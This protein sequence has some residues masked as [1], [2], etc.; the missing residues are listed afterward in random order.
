MLITQIIN[1]YPAEYLK[2]LVRVFVM[3]RLDS[4]NNFIII[5]VTEEPYQKSLMS[6]NLCCTTYHEREIYCG[7]WLTKVLYLKILFFTY[8]ALDH[9]APLYI[10]DLQ[11]IYPR[12]SLNFFQAFFSQLHEL[13]I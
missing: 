11:T 4:C 2:T 9:L 12:T 13:R 10:Q 8:K 7:S 6:P 5:W 3:C 1:T